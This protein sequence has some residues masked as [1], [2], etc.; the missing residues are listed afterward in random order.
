MH[1]SKCHINQIWQWKMPPG[2]ADLSINLCLEKKQLR[3]FRSIIASRRSST[4]SRNDNVPRFEREK[5]T[6][7]RSST[8]S[9]NDNFSSFKPRKTTWSENDNF[10]CSKP[11]K[12][13][14]YSVLNVVRKRQFPL[15]RNAKKTANIR[16]SMWSGNDNF[17]RFEPRKNNVVGKWQFPPLRT[18]KKLQTIGPQ[19]VEEM[20]IS[21]ASNREK[22]YKYLVLNVVGERQFPPLRTVKKTTK[23]T[24]INIH[25]NIWNI[26][27]TSFAFTY[28]HYIY[29]SKAK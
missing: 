8:W 16:S 2:I 10:P 6:N 4:W 23:K 15:L 5:P 17:P 1:F 21:P 7:I 29:N 28:I 9:G 12:N 25:E 20:T 11:Q 26:N 3:I 13:Y 22:N 24:R 18:A 14:E 27:K 19:H